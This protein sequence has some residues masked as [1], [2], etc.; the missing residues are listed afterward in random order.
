MAALFAFL[1][2]CSYIAYNKN[3]SNNKIFQG[4][5][6]HILPGE[7]ARNQDSEQAIDGRSSYKRAKTNGMKVFCYLALLRSTLIVASK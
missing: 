3:L 7:E 5:M 6:L 2:V 4:R 1:T